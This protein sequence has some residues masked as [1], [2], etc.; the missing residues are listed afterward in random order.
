MAEDCKTKTEKVFDLKVNMLNKKV[1]YEP[2]LVC[3]LIC[4]RAE[5]IVPKGW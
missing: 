5:L 1:N 4:K 2:K 3:S